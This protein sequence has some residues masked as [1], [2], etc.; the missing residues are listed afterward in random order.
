MKNIEISKARFADHVTSEI[1]YNYIYLFF[2][3]NFKIIS[4]NN[5][6]LLIIDAFELKY[7]LKIFNLIINIR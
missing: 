5:G 1:V 7:V 4:T 6:K 3:F 2:L